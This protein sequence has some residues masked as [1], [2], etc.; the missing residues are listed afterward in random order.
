MDGS[1]VTQDKQFSRFY[2][3][4]GPRLQRGHM[5]PS[6]GNAS[7]GASGHIFGRGTPSS[8]R[9]HNVGVELPARPG[10]SPPRERNDA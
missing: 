3:G 6:K 8:R 5:P 10:S 7:E 9:L 4:G 1:A 2:G